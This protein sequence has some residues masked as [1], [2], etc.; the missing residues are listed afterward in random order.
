MLASHIPWGNKWFTTR[1]TVTTTTE[2][3]HK[4]VEVFCGSGR[5]EGVILQRRS[6]GIHLLSRSFSGGLSILRGL[7]TQTIFADQT[8]HVATLAT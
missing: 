7:P 8:V 6:V 2:M 3:Q 4:T 1:E 5:V